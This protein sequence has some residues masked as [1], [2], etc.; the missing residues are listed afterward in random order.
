[1]RRVGQRDLKRSRWWVGLWLCL[2]VIAA[3]GPRSPRFASETDVKIAAFDFGAKPVPIWANGALVAVDE[4]DALT[5]TFHIFNRNG[6]EVRTAQFSIPGS[7]W[8]RVRG[9]SVGPDGSVA[10]CGDATD[11]RGQVGFYLALLPARGGQ[12]RIVQTFPYSPQAI[13]VAPDGSIWTKGLEY[14]PSRPKLG[15]LATRPADVIRHFDASGKFLG[16]FLEQTTMTRGELESGLSNL[17]ASA[18]VVGWYQGGASNYYEL[19]RDGS[20]KRWP[21]LRLAAREHVM[22]LAITDSG[23]VFVAKLVPN[24]KSEVY[25]LDRGAGTWIPVTLS[26]P[27]G[28]QPAPDTIV[29]ASGDTLVGFSSAGTLCFLRLAD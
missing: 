29:G 3:A 7:N 10:V 1:M 24:K 23:D 27:P 8:L 5:P 18:S 12:A 20:V 16:S 21:A 22:R 13:A 19:S 6:V 25:R 15:R 4:M 9:Y 14:D 17:A 11:Q 28:N 26:A 2:L